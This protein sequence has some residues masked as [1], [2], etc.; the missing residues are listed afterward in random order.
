MADLKDTY[1]VHGAR[2]TC[3]LGMRESRFVL[4]R[5]HG[6]FLKGWPQMNVKNCKLENIICFEAVTA[7]KIRIL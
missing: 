2:S 6:V 4:E 3:T 7:W 1:V 5:T